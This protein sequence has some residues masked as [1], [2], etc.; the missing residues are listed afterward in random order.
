MP[1]DLVPSVAAMAMEESRFAAK[2]LESV[3]YGVYTP[4][5]RA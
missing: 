4:A 2:T 5:S 3:P 1:V